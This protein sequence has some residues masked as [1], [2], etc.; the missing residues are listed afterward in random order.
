MAA[1]GIAAKWVGSASCLLGAGL[2]G[3]AAAAGE[4]LRRTLDDERVSV[5]SGS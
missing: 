4:L 3:P 5:T 1:P 2:W